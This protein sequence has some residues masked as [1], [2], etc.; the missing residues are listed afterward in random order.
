VARP[1][2][3]GDCLQ[4]RFLSQV[5]HKPDAPAI[6]AGDQL[7]TFRD[8]DRRANQI[9][10]RLLADG[11]LPGAAAVIDLRRSIDLVATLL[12]IWKTGAHYVPLHESHPPYWRDLVIRHSGARV[13]VTDQ[14]THATE[15]P[16]GCHLVDAN[17][18]LDAMMPG[19]DPSIR[20]EPNALALILFT[21]GSAGA[22]M[23]L[24][25]TH[26][27]LLDLVSD[28][29]SRGRRER[30]PLAAPLA[31]DRLVYELWVPLL[32]GRCCVLAPPETST[33][34]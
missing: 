2:P 16:P 9:A 31:D 21:A 22:P 30:V 27:E 14:T 10:H 33:C 19:T 13:L 20:S 25:V 5:A 11:A 6:Q 7:V 12:G 3:A 8:L 4:D 23:E 29:S 1:H 24:P 34:R 28:R 15:I 26:V 18:A 17:L 32:M